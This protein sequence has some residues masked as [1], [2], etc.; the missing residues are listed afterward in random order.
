MVALIVPHIGSVQ[1][2]VV[3]R[4][5]RSN[6]PPVGGCPGMAYRDDG[7]LLL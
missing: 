7:F 5:Y 4:Y 3:M 1:K 6:P 2:A